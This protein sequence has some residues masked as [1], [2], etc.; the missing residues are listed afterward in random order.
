MKRVGEIKHSL[1]HQCCG[2][3]GMLVVGW[4]FVSSNI[5]VHPYGVELKTKLS[6]G[7]TPV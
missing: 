7:H 2:N 1:R 3:M 4:R 5:F 6:R